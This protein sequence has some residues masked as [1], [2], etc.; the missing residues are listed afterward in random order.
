MKVVIIY[1][2][3]STGGSKQNAAEL[4]R[5]LRAK[6]MTVSVLKTTHAGHGA[7]IAEKYAKQNEAIVLISSSGDG[8]YHEV[9]NGALKNGQSKLV[10]GV[11][12]SGNANDHS[13][14]L[15]GKSLAEAIY[16]QS[17]QKIDTIKVSATVKGQPWV[18]YAHSYAGL[19]VTATAAK[20]LTEER[21]N[22]LTENWIV[23]HSLVSFNYAKI[24]EGTKTH[25]YS[26]ILF[27][28]IDR[29]SKI[30]KLSDNTSVKDGKFEF[31][32]IR[33][34]SK[35]RL[36]V[37]LFKA[38]TVGLKKSTSRKSYRFKTINALPIQLDGEVYT[39]DKN[40]NVKVESVKQ[41]L[42]CVL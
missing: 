40:T 32:A 11:L 35:L 28:N 1:N 33:F 15:G 2:P 38:A 41:N 39:I 23:L 36:I 30:M 16:K 12:A 37:Y 26:S 29:M 22:A 7:E 20:R 13:S 34:R 17:F 19:G 10:V 8:G 24:Q 25:R 42:H 9:V 6:S 27:G 4:A 31:T 5:Q 21:P 14:A 3:N 18:R